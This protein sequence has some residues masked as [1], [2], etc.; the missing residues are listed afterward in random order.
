MNWTKRLLTFLILPML[1]IAALAGFS[2][3]LGDGLPVEQVVQMQLQSD[4][5][6]V[7]RPF[8]ADGIFR[9]KMATILAQEPELLIA[10]NSVADYIQ[11]HWFEEP[12]VVV[13]A[14]IFGANVVDTIAQLNAIPT[15]IFPETILYIFS[16]RFISGLHT[17]S[18]SN[19]FET[20]PQAQPLPAHIGAAV[21]NQWQYLT[22][23]G[24]SLEQLIEQK[25][26][27]GDE[28]VLGVMG[29]W[30]RQGWVRGGGGVNG[31]W[32]RGTW[33]QH[34][35]KREENLAEVTRPLEVIAQI[36]REQTEQQLAVAYA[37]LDE[38]IDLIERNDATLILAIAPTF[39]EL[40][41]HYESAEY[42]PI[43][44][45]MTDYLEG[46]SA[47]NQVYFADYSHVE[48][49][50][51][52]VINF[53]DVF[54]M[55]EWLT[56]Q[57][58]RQ[59]AID[60]PEAFGR[61]TN[62]ALL[63]AQLQPFQHPFDLQGVFTSFNQTR[64]YLFASAAWY[65]EQGEFTRA[66]DLISQ[67]MDASPADA[68]AFSGLLTDAQT[69]LAQ[70]DMTQAT[71][72]LTQIVGLSPEAND[73]MFLSAQLLLERGDVQGTI[74]ILR[75]IANLSEDDLGFDR[76][77]LVSVETSLA[78]GDMTQA[79]EL[80]TQ[81]VGLSPERYEALL[82][83][84]ESLV[85]QGDVEEGIAVYTQIL[86]VLPDDPDI[87]MARGDAYVSLR[88]FE[89]ARD[90]YSTVLT[91]QPDH[92]F[93]MIKRATTYE[94][95]GEPALALED[96]DLA[97]AEIDGLGKRILRGRLAYVNEEYDLA[98]DDMTAALSFD[99][100]HPVPY[101]WRGLTYCWLG[102]VELA[103][104]DFEQFAQWLPENPTRGEIRQLER[105]NALDCIENR[106]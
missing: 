27:G 6:I 83:R 42:E 73:N 69:S 12:D 24:V 71:E 9:Y 1:V 97:L 14:S 66:I 13:N 17:F 29:V 3:W 21:Q 10:G 18:N 60:L 33:Q 41:T 98:I 67:V 22:Q 102:E 47:N 8:G 58:V 55:D 88:N 105:V 70:G 106:A 85:E 39:P 32:S 36:P 81:I 90:D 50:G 104:G 63:D 45:A 53:I 72:L 80:L 101:Y 16:P 31:I 11:S 23:R 77:V 79:T 74:D 49:L 7:Y 35:N 94:Q 92:E 44:G 93:A 99:A 52:S 76:D 65:V 100:T 89:L 54:H 87:S 68:V 64:D 96:A 84:A 57:L 37:R 4:D 56:L 103:M 2:M 75:Q 40:I 82:T 19:F 43:Y 26:N 25:L 62:P 28:E 15:E 20:V 91:L 59:L 46:L 95:L 48:S 34:W 78:Q 51:G 86:S 5:M 61:Y 38:F 30:L